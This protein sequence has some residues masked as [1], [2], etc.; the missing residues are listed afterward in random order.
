M[1]KIKGEGIILHPVGRLVL[2]FSDGV[3]NFG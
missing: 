1:E 2:T 3:H